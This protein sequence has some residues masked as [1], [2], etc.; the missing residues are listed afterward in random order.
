MSYHNTGSSS[1][2]AN[3][4]TNNTSSNANRVAV[5]TPPVVATPPITNQPIAPVGF[6]YMPDGSLMADADMAP[7]GFH[8]MPDGSL[9][10][11]ADMAVAP[12]SSAADSQG[13]FDC[14]DCR[15]VASRWNSN[16]IGGYRLSNPILG[17][18]RIVVDPLGT[19]FYTLGTGNVA[20]NGNKL[21]RQMEYINPAGVAPLSW[22]IIR[23]FEIVSVPGKNTCSLSHVRDVELP[24]YLS[25]LGLGMTATTQIAG[26][27]GQVLTM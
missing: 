15:V 19:S 7:V 5:V 6:H 10:A 11:D 24:D 25:V 21:Y 8:Y 23:E 13:P 20:K 27:G 26:P 9:M 3:Q 14:H 1:S 2:N 22:P 16:G 12:D 4:R 17:T 18:H